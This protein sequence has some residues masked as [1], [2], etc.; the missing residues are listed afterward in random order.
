MSI[1]QDGQLKGAFSGFHNRDT[2]F[3]FY[4][5][6]VWRQNEYKYVYHYAYMPFAKVVDRGGA[7]YLEVEGMD[8]SV[9]VVRVR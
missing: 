7:Q 5:G 6:G 3:E 9:Q 1:V 2:L 8:D 4:G